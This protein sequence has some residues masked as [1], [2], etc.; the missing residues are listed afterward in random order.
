MATKICC[1][2]KCEKELT[3]FYKCSRNKDGVQSACKLCIAEEQRLYRVLHPE[4][5]KEK[6]KQKYIKNSEKRKRDVK[7]WRIKNNK[8]SREYQRKYREK[9][10]PILKEKRKTYIEQNTE[11]VKSIQIKYYHKN[12]DTVASRRKKYYNMNRMR[13]LN[14]MKIKYYNNPE[15]REKSRKR[16]KQYRIKH[17]DRLR[18]KHQEYMRSP[19]GR[20]AS[21]RCRHRRVSKTKKTECTLTLEQ[22][23]KILES[24]QY[25]CVGYPHGNCNKK[26]GKKCKPSKD[27]I[28][29]VALNGPFT[30]ENTQALC[31]SCNSRKKANLDHGLLQ[32]WGL[33]Y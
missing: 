29:P 6:N 11:K 31:K 10:K 13:I 5:E 24:Q 9:N 15:E 26:F 1:R 25:R 16:N 30:Y 2:C 19:R 18:I 17:A 3:L 28:I 23:D 21:S 20:L 32:G 4:K 27:H 12:K 33:T 7:E 14:T 22:W 8:W